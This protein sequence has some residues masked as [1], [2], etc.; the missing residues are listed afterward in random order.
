MGV[1]VGMAFYVYFFKRDEFES[2]NVQ[3]SGWGPSVFESVGFFNCG[4]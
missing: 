3:E 1:G 2:D 4:R